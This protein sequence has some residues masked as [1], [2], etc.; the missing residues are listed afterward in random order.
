MIL[1]ANQ[2][3]QNIVWLI[4]NGSPPIRYLTHKHL[5]KTP[6]SSEM[7]TGLWREVQTCRDADQ[8][9]QKIDC[10]RRSEIPRKYPPP[11]FFDFRMS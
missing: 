4:K 9:S 11:S 3:D 2:I 7:M 10:S 6:G 1:T 8:T 5:L